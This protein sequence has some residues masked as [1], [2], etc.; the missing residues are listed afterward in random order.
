[1]NVPSGDYLILMGMGGLF[2]FLGLVSVI[3]GKTE[4]KRY[5]DSLSTRTDVR[6]FLE[7][8]PE[9]PQPGALKIGGWIA[10]AVGLLMVAMGSAFWLW[11]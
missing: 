1:M 11:G 9:H 6:E 8:E 3:W 2:I 10:I 4:E 7:H 5:Y